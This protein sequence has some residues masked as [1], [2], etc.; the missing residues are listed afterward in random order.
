MSGEE[1]ATTTNNKIRCTFAYTGCTK[2]HSDSHQRDFS[3]LGDPD[4]H[5][6]K[7]SKCPEAYPCHWYHIEHHNDLYYHETDNVELSVSHFATSSPGGGPLVTRVIVSS[8]DTVSDV[9]R[10]VQI[11]MGYSEGENRDTIAEAAQSEVKSIILPCEMYLVA[12]QKKKDTILLDTSKIGPFICGHSISITPVPRFWGSR[13]WKVDTLTQG[14]NKVAEEDWSIGSDPKE[15][16]GVLW[17]YLATLFQICVLQKLIR[18]GTDGSV[19]FNT[20]LKTHDGRTV[21]AKLSSKNSECCGAVT[22]FCAHE[23]YASMPFPTGLPEE[24]YW[25]DT[26]FL[27][28][29]V[30]NTRMAV[31]ADDANLPHLLERLQQRCNLSDFQDT[32]GWDT[33][34]NS[35][36]INWIRGLVHQA[37]SRA[38]QSYAMVVPCF[39]PKYQSFSFLLPIFLKDMKGEE[40]A[41]LCLTLAKVGN[42]YTITTCLDLKQSY[43]NARV[44]S[45]PFSSWLTQ[46]AVKEEIQHEEISRKGRGR[47]GVGGGGRGKKRGKKG[48]GRGRSGDGD[49]DGGGGAD[50]GGGEGGGEGEMSPKPK[51]GKKSSGTKKGTVTLTTSQQQLL[52]NIQEYLATLDKPAKVAQLLDRMSALSYWGTVEELRSLLGEMKLTHLLKTQPK[53]IFVDQYDII[54]G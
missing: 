10:K 30:F 41:V 44:I 24:I 2:E 27:P 33:W 49:G 8:H 45:K 23:Q 26:D 38:Q 1:D 20:K 14:P 6:S 16:Y 15:R 46:N 31:Q 43:C 35:T 9:K 36:K 13:F 11:A 28:Y 34:N 12:T 47:V 42:I 4:W 21:W 25:T 39:Y 19:A 7:R 50:G 22:Y 54:L 32:A 5:Q 53:I 3:H 52:D 48:V 29:L 17:R 51:T 40:K 37:F 18:R